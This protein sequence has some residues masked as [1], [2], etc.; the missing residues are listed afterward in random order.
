MSSPGRTAVQFKSFIETTNTNTSLCRGDSGSPLFQMNKRKQYVQIGIASSVEQKCTF[1]TNGNVVVY[2]Q[3]YTLD[4]GEHSG[5]DDSR[6]LSYVLD[7]AHWES[8]FMEDF[9]ILIPSIDL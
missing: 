5:K 9:E 7:K 6:C 1:D 4:R 3:R 8:M 2:F